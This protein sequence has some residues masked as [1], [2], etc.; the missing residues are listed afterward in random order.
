MQLH[1]YV[2]LPNFLGIMQQVG[3]LFNKLTLTSV[4][5]TPVT[6]EKSFT[7]FRII[8]QTTHN[9]PKCTKSLVIAVEKYIDMTKRCLSSGI[10]VHE[11]DVNSENPI[12]SLGKPFRSVQ[13]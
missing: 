8:S 3:K 6:L 7:G 11:R 13:D 4:L 10:I 1:F 12:S 5:S 9:I 2:R